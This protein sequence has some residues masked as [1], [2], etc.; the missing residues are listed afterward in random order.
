MA[1]VKQLRR[2]QGWIIR[3]P[4]R[5]FLDP[6]C[7]NK[8][9]LFGS[10][11][12]LE[13]HKIAVANGAARACLEHFAGGSGSLVVSPSEDPVQPEPFCIGNPAGDDDFVHVFDEAHLHIVMQELDTINDFVE[14]LRSRKKVIVNKNLVV[15]ASE[16]DL[17]ASYFR[18]PLGE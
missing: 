15:S 11:K 1:S 5:I 16:E 12:D 14:Y 4:H 17:L 8:I 13:I 6:K 3:Q 2:A 9:D 10:R 18:V 7:E